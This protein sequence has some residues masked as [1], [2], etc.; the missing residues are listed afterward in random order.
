MV[1]TGHRAEI[2]A[3]SNVLYGALNSGMV[4]LAYVLAIFLALLYIKHF[5]DIDVWHILATSLS[6]A[7]IPFASDV[8]GFAEFL[9]EDFIITTVVLA[10]VYAAFISNYQFKI[11]GDKVFFKRGFLFLKKE[12]FELEDVEQVYVENYPFFKSTGQLCIKA[13]DEDIIK[14]PY[15]K[16]AEEIKKQI[17]EKVKKRHQELEMEEILHAPIKVMSWKPQ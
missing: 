1:Q 16:K 3:R 6:S 12:E 13:L 5:H 17:I 11:E 14:L 10:L 9:I 8:L 15:V 2:D 4:I 7:R